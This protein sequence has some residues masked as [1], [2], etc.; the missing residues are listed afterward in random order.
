MQ[1]C[2]DLQHPRFAA[3]EDKWSDQIKWAEVQKNSLEFANYVLT[4]DTKRLCQAVSSQRMAAAGLNSVVDD[5]TIASRVE[6]VLLKGIKH[7]KSH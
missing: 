5:D 1:R 6:V 4:L 3:D 2:T 7:A